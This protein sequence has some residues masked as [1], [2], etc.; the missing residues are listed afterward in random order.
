MRIPLNHLS[1][2]LSKGGR[3][4]RVIITLNSY[5]NHTMSSADALPYFEVDPFAFSSAVA[6]QNY[7]SRCPIDLLSD[8]ATHVIWIGAFNGANEVSAN[9]FNVHIAIPL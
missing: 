1:I 9:E 4:R 8:F 7:R 3:N 6:D 5:S 2:N